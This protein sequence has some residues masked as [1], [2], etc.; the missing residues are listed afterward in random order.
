MKIIVISYPN[1]YPNEA[2]IIN[3]LFK[4]GLDILHLRKPLYS[5]E[6]MCYLLDMINIE[7][8]NRIVIH[9]HYDLYLNNIYDLNGIHLTKDSKNYINKYINTSSKVSVST[10]SFDEILL[11][12]D[13]TRYMFISPVFD[14]ISKENYKSNISIEKLKNNSY[15]NKLVALGGIQNIN[16]ESIKKLNLYGIALLGHIWKKNHEIENFK[17]IKEIVNCL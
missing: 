12:K 5:K 6:A 4:N 17:I 14:S 11:F 7:Y 9:S 10:H 8:H 15:I 1:R 16:I 13:K 3:D 2:S